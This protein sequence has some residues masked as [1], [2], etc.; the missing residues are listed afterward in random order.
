MSIEN[1]QQSVV[2]VER[3]SR[4][5]PPEQMLA[6]DVRTTR[7]FSALCPASVQ[8]RSHGR[9]LRMFDTACRQRADTAAEKSVCLHEA[10]PGCSGRDDK[11]AKR[12]Q[13]RQQRQRR[14]GSSEP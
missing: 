1:S 3:D 11:D 8:L 12:H 14:P 10:R 5:P 6:C 13:R 4:R 2:E 9:H 7:A